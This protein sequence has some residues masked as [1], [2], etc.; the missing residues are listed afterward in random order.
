[1]KVLDCVVIGAGP[2]GLTA[3][4][5]LARYLRDVVV[6]EDG[7]SRALWIPRSHN[8]PGY[9]DGIPGPELIE[10]LRQQAARYSAPLI[11]ERVETL[12]RLEDGGFRVGLKDRTIA[13]QTVILATGA[14]DVQPP[15]A[16]RDDA[17][18]RG[19]LRHCPTCDAYEVRDCRVAIIG[20]G[21]CRVQEAM[22][23]RTYTADLTVLSLGRELEMAEDERAELHAAGIRLVDEPVADLVPEGEAVCAR[24]ARSGQVLRFDTV[25]AAL[26]LRGRSELAVRL[27]AAHDDDGMLLVDEHQRTSVPW[28]YAVGDVAAGLTQ[29]GVAMGHA[30]V[31][32]NSISSS[33][34]RRLRP[35]VGATSS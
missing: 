3:A 5:Y 1:M 20:A 14:D 33:L 31:A 21:D 16:D 12:E 13:A 28:L 22:L 9:P 15:I 34:E 6:I 10:R 8:C 23:L 11:S 17:I 30:A 29:I 4:I 7:R 24:L 25:Y 18:R 2:G 35:K 19:L 32:A 26:G 27:G